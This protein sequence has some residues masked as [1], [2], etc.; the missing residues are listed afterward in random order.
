[1]I[2][3]T[4]SPGILALILIRTLRRDIARYNKDEELVSELETTDRVSFRWAG[5][6]H[7]PPRVVCDPLEFCYFV[8][9]Y[10]APPPQIL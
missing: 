8:C 4:T 5:A 2:C 7:P 1:M 6:F 10:I 9:K 3:S